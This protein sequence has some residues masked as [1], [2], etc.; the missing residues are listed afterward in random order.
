MP[1]KW[2][3]RPWTRV[4][5]YFAGPFLNHMFFILI[6]SHSKWIEVHP[7]SS[8]TASATIQC[9]CNIF[10]QFGIP[11]NV[12]FDNG[13]TFTSM[14][15]KQFL[16][17]NGVRHTTSP[18]YHPASNGLVER[19]VQIFK[20]SVA[21]MTD[22]TVQTK[23]ARFL[24]TYRTPPQS[25][26]GMSP[27]EL[28]LGRRLKSALDLMKPNLQH[29]VEKEQ[30]RQKIAHD[31]R[32]VNR[33]FNIGEKVYTR[34][35]GQG[36]KWLPAKVIKKLGSQLFT[37]ELVQNKMVWRRHLNQLRQ[38]YGEDSDLLG[39]EKNTSSQAPREPIEYPFFPVEGSRVQ[40]PVDIAVDVAPESDIEQ[41]I[42]PRYPTRVRHL[43]D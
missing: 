43:P 14:E 6:D 28:L 42:L 39:T 5:I 38:R 9:L 7:L 24:F 19:A 23:I 4:H 32:A 12:V 27:S 29:Q 18:P 2:P 25:T 22:E 15:F 3:N 10:A 33:T 36:E 31:C 26:T 34:N 21:K 13:P 35:Y 40:M 11:E 16:Q 1:W 41:P 17:R 8:I 20:H 30:E 37:V